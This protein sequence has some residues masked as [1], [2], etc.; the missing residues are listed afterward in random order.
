MSENRDVQVPLVRMSPNPT[1]FCRRVRELSEDTSRIKWSRHARDRMVERD[2][3]IR[4]ALSVIRGGYLAGAIVAGSNTGEWKAKFVRKVPGR[5]DVG[6][7]FLLV[8]NDAL[9]V[10]TV[11]WE[12]VR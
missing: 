9:L 10:K 8:R 6:V 3:S 12:D 5:R 1:E 7:V 4:V 2:I 11:E